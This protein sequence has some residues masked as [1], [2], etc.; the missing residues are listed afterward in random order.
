MATTTPGAIEELVVAVATGTPGAFARLHGLTE[1]SIRASVAHILIDPWQSEEVT[2][3][4][5]LEVWQK[6]SQFDARLG[7]AIGW[8]FTIARRR[9]IDRVRSAQAARDRDI[10]DAVRKAE[11]PYDPVWETVQARFDRDTVVQGLDGITQLQR[12]AL[13]S[14]YLHGRTIAQAAQHLGASES[15]IKARMSDGLA[16]L[17]RVIVGS[18][19]AA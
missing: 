9:A 3:E 8:M 4:V 2:Q 7:S 14:T 5:F 1:R 18:G 19:E 15:A 11:A 17:R 10:H 12:A 13:T 16:N 6:A